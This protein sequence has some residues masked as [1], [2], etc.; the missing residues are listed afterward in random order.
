MNGAGL[1][2][3]LTTS[4]RVVIKPNFTYP[5][6]KPGVT[7]SPQIIRE[8]VKFLREYTA[9]IAVVETDGGYGA[10]HAEEAFTGHGLYEMRDEFGIEIVNLNEEPREL[11]SFRSGRQSHQLPL[12]IRLLHETDLFS[13]HCAI[14]LRSLALRADS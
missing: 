9:H 11:I 4:C 2:R 13:G 7:M 8:T 10:W 3:H 6:Y 14:I 1:L 12:P 5:Y